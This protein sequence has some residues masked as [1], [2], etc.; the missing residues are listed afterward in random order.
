[1]YPNPGEAIPLP[2]RP[3][4]EQYKKLAKDLAEACKT[5]D[6]E[7]IRDWSRLWLEKL[8]RLVDVQGP[9]PPR[10]VQA[11]AESGC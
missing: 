9:R 6:S 10:L 11:S 1:V 3:N 8:A 4:L 2:P 7:A 5:G